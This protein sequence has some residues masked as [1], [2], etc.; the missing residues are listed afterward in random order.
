MGVI[1]A[2]SVVCIVIGCMSSLLVPM[3]SKES[4]FRKKT[5]TPHLVAVTILLP[6]ILIAWI[7]G[8]V[9]TDHGV[10]GAASTVTQYIFGCMLMIHAIILL[11]LTLIRTEDTRKAWIRLL[12]CKTGTTGKYAFA[13]D[14]TMQKD[15][16]NHEGIG[17]E[18]STKEE[19]EKLRSISSE[20]KE[21]LFVSDRFVMY[22]L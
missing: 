2:I 15:F 5:V 1:F 19:K 6:I 4:S 7:F 8:M 14:V 12:K 10:T 16:D 22:H 20:D 17:L 9:G 21:I 13:Q 11:I 3:K 18:V